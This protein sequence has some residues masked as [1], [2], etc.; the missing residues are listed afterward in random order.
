MTQLHI[1]SQFD[2]GAIDVVRLDD[3]RNIEVNIPQDSAAEFRQWFH[4]ALHGAQGKEV[5]VRFM[6]A[7]QCAYPQ[8][9]SDYSVVASHDRQHWFRI[10]TH[11]DGTVMSATL[12]PQTQC[13]YLAYFEPYSYEQHLDLLGSAAQS[14]H[15]QLHRL[16]STLLGRD[17]TMLRITHARKGPPEGERTK[18][19]LIA[20]QHPGETMAQWFSEGFL[21]RLLNTDDS[22]SRVLLERCVFYVVPNMNP[23]G[24]VLG[25]LRTNAAGANLNRE[26]LE[27]TLERSPEVFVVR[28]KMLE[29]GVDVCLDVHGDET[30]P[31]VFV[32]GSEGNPDYSPRQA[33]QE[34]IFKSAWLACCPDFQDEHHYGIKAPGQAVPTL[35]TNWVAQRFGGLAFTIEMPFK[36]NANLPDPAVGW[37][38]ARSRALGG[39]ILQPLLQ[40]LTQS[41]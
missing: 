16:G 30:L 6:N 8:G 31:Y 9:W 35:L 39:S 13:V 28:E 20:R 40:L 12:T 3:P 33:E 41:E 11:Y 25:N 32:V 19:W 7:A 34:V 21:E 22:V 2:S 29:L 26:W 36:D 10:D 24:G 1:S 14:E 4:F 15:V 5:T 18:V 37:S 23:D 27:P 38:S 17:M